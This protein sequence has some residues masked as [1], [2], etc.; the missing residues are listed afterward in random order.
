MVWIAIA[1]MSLV[2]V[3]FVIWPLSKPRDIVLDAGPG[4]LSFYRDQLRALDR[5]VADGLVSPTE[6]EG[7]RAEIGRRFLAAS[8]QPAAQAAPLAPRPLFALAVAVAVAVPVAS[9]ALYAR[10]GAPEDRDHP[11]AARLASPDP[12]D[13][14][15]AIAR[16]EAHLR[17][18]PEDGRGFALLAPI[19]VRLGRY[20]DAA[21][22]YERTLALLGESAD[23]RAALGEALMQAGGGS[24]TPDAKAA[25]T[26]ALEDD[27]K[28]PQARFYLGLAAAQ[29]GDKERA[30]ALLSGLLADSPP[31][32]PWV[33][34]VK[35]RLAMLDGGAAPPA[36]APEGPAAAAIAALPAAERLQS[37]H[38][39]VDGLASRLQ[40]EGHDPEGWLKLV[41]AYAVLG[42]AGKARDALADARRNLAS[43][44]GSLARLDGLAREL[45]LEG[46]G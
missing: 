11:L 32:A 13:F 37:I 45:G 27:P 35:S 28:L 22:A 3:A 12:D 6:A 44:A 19:Y 17:S 4:D 31:D 14:P 38:G 46:Q 8:D 23:R 2:A 10:I 20:A 21:Q 7:S 26:K 40:A 1:L 9:L 36:G 43:D 30:H 24:V 41:R 33:P 39:M 29:D 15:A 18:H 16:V 34:M 5:D 42:E 25:F